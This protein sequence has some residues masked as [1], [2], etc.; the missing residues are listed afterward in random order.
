MKKSREPKK[1][2]IVR[3]KADQSEW[4]VVDYCLGLVSLRENVKHSR[5]KTEVDLSQIEYTEEEKK[6]QKAP[7]PPIKLNRQERM[8]ILKRLVEESSIRDNFL[9]EVM[10]LSRLIRRFPHVDFWK[11]GFKPALKVN[12]LLYWENRPEVEKLYKDWAICLTKPVE[13]IKLEQNKVVEDL[14]I[15]K[16]A[17]NLLDLLG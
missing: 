17:R 16:K 10:V 14:P 5:K 12:S 15:R 11:E 4:K 3:L 2:E 13:E 8:E 9:R 1:G 7:P 6:K